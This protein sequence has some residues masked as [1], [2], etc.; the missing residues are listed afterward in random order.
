MPHTPGPWTVEEYGDDDC[1]ALV[2]HRDIESRVCFMA[3][4]GSRGDPEM[5]AADAKLSSGMERQCAADV[6]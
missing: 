2:I 1:P 4:L 6:S 3:T 5:I